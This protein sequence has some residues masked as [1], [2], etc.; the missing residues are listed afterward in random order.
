MIDDAEHDASAQPRSRD[1]S[2]CSA[3]RQ[4]LAFRSGAATIPH[5]EQVSRHHRLLD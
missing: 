1:T 5:R 3:I 4:F 2:C